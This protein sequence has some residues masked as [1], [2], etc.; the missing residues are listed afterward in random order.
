[1]DTH[2]WIWS[3]FGHVHEFSATGS[4]TLRQ[5][6]ADGILLV[7]IVSVWK[8]RFWNRNVACI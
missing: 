8:L 4:S 5:A 2:C 6:A 1:L 7:S 3:Q